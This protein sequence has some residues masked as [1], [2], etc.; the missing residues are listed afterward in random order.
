MLEGDALPHTI[1][2]F[3]LYLATIDC[4]VVT[5]SKSY[6]VGSPTWLSSPYFRAGQEDV[7]TTL[8]SSSAPPSPYTFTFSSPLPA[9]PNLAYG[10]KAYRGIFFN[11]IQELIP[12][13]NKSL[14]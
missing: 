10:F 11:K 3:L 4:V 14:K 6:A 9:T 8:T 2:Y 12:C 13:V 5:G 1:W 7:I